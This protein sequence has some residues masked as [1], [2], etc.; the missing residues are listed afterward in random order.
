MGTAP[1][2]LDSRHMPGEL[3][4][5]N[6]RSTPISRADRAL[7]LCRFHLQAL[8]RLPASLPHHP[9]DYGRVCVCQDFFGAD[10][11]NARARL[12]GH[13]ARQ[14]PS[15]G[16]RPLTCLESLLERHRLIY[17]VSMCGRVIQSAEPLRLAIVDG[18]DV[19]D[20]RT[21]NVRP[22]YNAA[23]SQE[24]LVIRENHETGERSLDII[25]WGL[26]PYWCKDP[27]GG[28]KPINA[29]GETVAKLPM[30]RDAYAKR[31]CIERWSRLSAQSFRV[32]KWSVC[33]G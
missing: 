14:S 5:D 23:P 9:R 29:K 17:L 21:S 4:V 7:L 6:D 8:P 28:R 11:V 13:D 32:D 25:K 31:R 26:I 20:S 2:G 22:R 15:K 3:G 30:F 16:F 19:S 33:R 24:L 1:S 12:I 10:V 27:K 18:L